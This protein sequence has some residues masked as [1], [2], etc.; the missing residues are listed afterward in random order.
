MIARHQFWRVFEI[1][2]QLQGVKF[3]WKKFTFEKWISKNTWLS[4]V[5][6]AWLDIFLTRKY[7]YYTISSII[8][9]FWKNEG[10]IFFTFFTIRPPVFIKLGSLPHIHAYITP[11]LL[12]NMVSRKQSS[13]CHRNF[14]ILSE[15]VLGITK[16]KKIEPS[17]FQNR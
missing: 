1:W 8:Y 15:L 5:I 6:S 7:S 4:H 2:P 9:R 13:R 16:V 3:V 11:N 10:S 17:F 14:K 12:K